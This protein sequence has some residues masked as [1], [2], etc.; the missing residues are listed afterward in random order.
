MTPSSISTMVLETALKINSL[1][2]GDL[3]VFVL[4]RPSDGSGG[5]LWAG[6]ER[7]SDEYRRQRLFPGAADVEVT[8]DPGTSALVRKECKADGTLVCQPF[9]PLG[10]HA[11]KTSRKR[12][13]TTQLF[14]ANKKSKVSRQSQAHD[15]NYD[16][17]Q[18]SNKSTSTSG[19]V[20]P[21]RNNQSHHA[22]FLADGSSPNNNNGGGGNAFS[23]VDPHFVSGQAFAAGAA[24]DDHNNSPFNGEGGGEDAGVQWIYD[25][26]IPRNP[27]ARDV[28]TIHDSSVTIKNSYAFKCLNTV[29]Y[30]FGREA[31]AKCPYKC[32]QLKDDACRLYFSQCF[33]AFFSHFPNLVELDRQK[34]GFHKTRLKKPYLLSLK[35][36]CRSVVQ[37]SFCKSFSSGGVPGGTRLLAIGGGPDL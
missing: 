1:A 22:S 6:D 29:L 31:Y 28:T 23:T 15:L 27:K 14:A 36:Y 20:P 33:D 17:D 3:E 11:Q 24:A 8:L 18:T 10:A 12:S 34:V 30:A 16:F 26:F 9:V 25:E 37:M 32:G 2:G 7:L 35:S 19:D 5:A 4:V 13:S 21:L